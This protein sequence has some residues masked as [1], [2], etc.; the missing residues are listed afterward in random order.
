M[1]P[2][3]TKRLHDAFKTSLEDPAVLTL[4][5]RYDAP[6]IYLNSADYTKFMRDTYA[7]EKATIERLGLA[8]KVT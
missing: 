1:D 7:A 5:D 6:V 4:L 2:A 3:I 8:Y